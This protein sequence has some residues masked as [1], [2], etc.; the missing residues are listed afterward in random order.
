MSVFSRTVEGLFYS[1]GSVL[2]GL[3]VEVQPGEDPSV[4]TLFDR[5]FVR[6]EGQYPLLWILQRQGKPANPEE[7]EK[8]LQAPTIGC[9]M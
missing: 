2:Q 3:E 5:V 8:D 6:Q 7:K 4:L 9:P 1:C